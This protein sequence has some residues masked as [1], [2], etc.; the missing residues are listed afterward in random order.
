MVV[1]VVWIITTKGAGQCLGLLDQ[2]FI[3]LQAGKTQA[4]LPGL[5][6]AHE[7]ARAALLQ[8]AAGNLK[9]ISGFIHGAQAQAGNS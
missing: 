2:I 7:L 9:A 8:V 3:G 6:H 4:C 1:S 5:A